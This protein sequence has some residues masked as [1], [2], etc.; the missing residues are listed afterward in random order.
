MDASAGLAQAVELESVRKGAERKR[1]LWDM[2]AF[3][4][5]AGQTAGPAGPGCQR[6]LQYNHRPRK[7]LPENGAGDRVDEAVL[8]ALDGRG[9]QVLEPQ[10]SGIS[11]EPLGRRLIG[12]NLRNR[13]RM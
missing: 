8:G 10:R 4:R 11:R 1:S 5:N 9:R 2:Q 12:G 13:R 3:I 7:S 6:F